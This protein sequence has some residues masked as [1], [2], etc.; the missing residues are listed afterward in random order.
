MR[1]NDDVDVQ[2]RNR[3]F[4]IFAGTAMALWA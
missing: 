4:A 1:H 3:F 2:R